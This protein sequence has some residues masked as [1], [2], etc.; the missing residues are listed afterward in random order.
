M[1]QKERE[2][3]LRSFKNGTIQT[4]VATDV[5]SRGIDVKGIELVVNYDVPK[6]GEDYVHRIGR[7]ARADTTGEAITLVSHR[8]KR[9][10]Q[11][12]EEL[13]EKKVDRPELP[14]WLKPR[15]GDRRDERRGGN[16]NR[17]GGN[18][19][20]GG[21]N[22]GGRNSNR[23]GGSSRGRGPKPQGARNANRG[24]NSTGQS[25]KPSKGGE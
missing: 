16:G 8:D 14:D 25:T 4:V 5:L 10:F 13:I 22:R 3:V 24:D 20:G 18:R 17:G 6:G 23:S 1:E 9:D 21:G 7:T 19:R 15:G 2:Q 11:Q 12:I